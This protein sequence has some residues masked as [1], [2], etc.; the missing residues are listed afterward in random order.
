MWSWTN[1]TVSGMLVPKCHTNCGG[2]GPTYQALRMKGTLTTSEI[3]LQYR[4]DSTGLLHPA[5][6][7]S[8]PPPPRSDEHCYKALLEGAQ[9]RGANQLRIL[10][11]D[12]KRKALARYH[13]SA[14][15]EQDKT[16]LEYFIKNAKYAV[17]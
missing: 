14:K 2:F 5:A 6:A 1:I 12:N 9:I 11:R 10:I 13:T 16:K 3:L 4:W 7:G 8:F 17:Q 15:A